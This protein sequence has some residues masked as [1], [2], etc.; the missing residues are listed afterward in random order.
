MR[1]VLESL[2]EGRAEDAE[3]AFGNLLEQLPEHPDAD[4]L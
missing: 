3:Q 4:M 1:Q 2:Q